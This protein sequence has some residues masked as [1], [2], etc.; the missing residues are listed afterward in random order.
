MLAE[1]LLAH[2]QPR[3]SEPRFGMARLF[4]RPKRMR[5]RVDFQLIDL[6]RIMALLARNSVPPAVAI[7]WLAPRCASPLGSR[8]IQI[9][10]D[11]DLGGDL[12]VLLEQWAAQQ[13]DRLLL[14]L[15]QK[16][17]LS[18]IPLHRAPSVVAR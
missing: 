11:L 13:P 9:A 14:E 6:V 16:L 8:L 7:A 4:I 15:V 2:H 12:G 3:Q 18:M 10:S 1:R 5:S 17:K